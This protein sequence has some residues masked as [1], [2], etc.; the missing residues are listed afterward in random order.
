MS[1][2]TDDTDSETDPEAES[3]PDAESDSREWRF[4][5]DDVGPEAESDDDRLPIEPGSPSLENVVFVV[6]GV[7]LTLVLLLSVVNP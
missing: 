2:P 5:L 4:G 7:L 1:R 6:L 3:D